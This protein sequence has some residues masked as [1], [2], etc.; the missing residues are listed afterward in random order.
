[1]K[2]AVL[3]T[4]YS[5]H[6]GYA[7]QTGHAMIYEF[8]HREDGHYDID[9]YNTDAG[10]EYHEGTELDAEYKSQHVVRFENVVPE[11]LGFS[12]KNS[13]SCFFSRS[14]PRSILP[15]KKSYTN[16]QNCINKSDTSTEQSCWR[17]TCQNSAG[18]FR[19]HHLED[20]PDLRGLLNGCTKEDSPLLEDS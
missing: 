17:F 12:E 14:C 2:A 3:Q 8:T 10:I 19:E 7:D 9:V 4:F 18:K 11:E 5:P 16:L 1:M 13:S 20:P 6:G 15:F